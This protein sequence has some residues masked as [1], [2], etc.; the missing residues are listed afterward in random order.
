[1]AE[2]AIRSVEGEIVWPGSRQRVGWAV[3]PVR[4]IRGYQRARKGRGDAMSNGLHNWILVGCNAYDEYTFVSWLGKDVYRRTVNLASVCIQSKGTDELRHCRSRSLIALR[5]SQAIHLNA[6][7]IFRCTSLAAG[8]LFLPLHAFLLPACQLRPRQ[9]YPS[10][11]RTTRL[12]SRWATDVMPCKWTGPDSRGISLERHAQTAS[13]IEVRLVRKW[14]RV[15]SI[16][17]NWSMR[18]VRAMPTQRR[19]DRVSTAACRTSIV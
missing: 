13:S 11:R 9:P 2:S 8:S 12:L 14:A 6:K 16:A 7:E 10:S 4:V 18:R 5:S 19:P 15:R 3:Q 17:E 1:M